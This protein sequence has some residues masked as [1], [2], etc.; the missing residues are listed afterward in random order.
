MKVIRKEYVTNPEFDPT[1][2]AKASSAAEGKFFFL[3]SYMYK[4][5]KTI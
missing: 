1:K 4:Y 2:V 5:C 3:R